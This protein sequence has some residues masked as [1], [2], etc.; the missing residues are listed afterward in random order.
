MSAKDTML[1][2]AIGGGAI[3][4]G[5][6]MRCSAIAAQARSQDW[7]VVLVTT[8]AEKI[9]FDVWSRMGADIE[10]LT[11][12]VV[13][14]GADQGA[15]AIVQLAQRRSA[16]VLLI[17]RYDL[18]EIFWTMIA[19]SLRHVA[20]VDDLGELK[21]LGGVKGHFDLI[22]NPNPGA[23]QNY[24]DSY[25]ASAE[26]LLGAQYALIRPQIAQQIATGGNGILVA[27]GGGRT[28]RLSEEI[29]EALCAFST[30]PQITLIG[31]SGRKWPPPVT[32]VPECDIAPLL[33][34]ADVVVCGAGVTALEAA[35][36]ARPAV[37]MPLADNQMPGASALTSCGA[38][39]LVKDANACATAVSTLLADRSLAKRMGEQGS[40]LI[41]GRGAERVM[42]KIIGL[43]QSLDGR[44]M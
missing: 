18:N 22:I 31:P 25:G 20:I 37:I 41:D 15:D 4:Y 38:A 16:D 26:L 30:T 13:L 44:R 34:A 12:E 23:E 19:S 28:D 10:I 2:H 43:I 7:D 40:G 9:L 35:V 3:G 42:R 24:Q 27:M 39:I 14:D 21:G 8:T 36:L 17:D 11:P 32:I 6:L 33:A 1:V 5:H 29:V